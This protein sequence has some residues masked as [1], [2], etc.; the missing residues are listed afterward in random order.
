[1][2]YD[3]DH[4]DMIL[5]E[6]EGALTEAEIRLGGLRD[7]CLFRFKHPDRKPEALRGVLK[8]LP[9]GISTRRA[10]HAVSLLRAW[11]YA[12]CATCSRRFRS[13]GKRIRSSAGI[14]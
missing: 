7:C 14:C 6:P 10:S 4:L 13:A 3:L 2:I 1:M 8:I 5:D 12:A 9:Y 11:S